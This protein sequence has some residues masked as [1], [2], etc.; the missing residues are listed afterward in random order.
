MEDRKSKIQ[1]LQQRDRMDRFVQLKLYE[2]R[3]V[4]PNLAAKSFL[5]R[6]TAKGRRPFYHDWQHVPVLNLPNL[7]LAFRHAQ[8][9]QAD[10][11]GWLVLIQFAKNREDLVAAFTGKEF[12]RRMR[13]QGSQRDYDWLN[14]F[15]DRISGTQVRVSVSGEVGSGGRLY[16]YAEALAPRYMMEVTQSLYSLELSKVLWAFFGVDGWSHIDIEKRLALGQNQMA[17]AFYAFILANQSPYWTTWEELHSLWGQGFSLAKDFKH[18][19][20][21][22]VLKPLLDQGVIT[23]VTDKGTALVVFW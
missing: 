5:F 7:E 22:R 16:R 18:R 19:F 23:R 12:L 2:R 6:P 8:L 9:D 14:A 1:A 20:Q 3:S 4:L 13:K 21:N 15:V 10:L 17:M 11:T